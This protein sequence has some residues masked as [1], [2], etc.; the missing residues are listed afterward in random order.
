MKLVA[1]ALAS[2]IGINGL[3]VNLEEHRLDYSSVPDWQTNCNKVGG[4]VCGI[5]DKDCC[6]GGCTRN[7]PFKVD[8]VPG[9]RLSPGDLE[10][11]ARNLG[12]IK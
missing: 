10:Q 4:A 2:L 1:L 11:R 9:T 5:N 3:H 7:N 8:C 6:T 12:Y